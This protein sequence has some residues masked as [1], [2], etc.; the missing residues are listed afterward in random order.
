VDRSPWLGL[1]S[2]IAR[3]SAPGIRGEA[4]HGDPAVPRRLEWR[5][6][7][8]LSTDQ[9]QLIVSPADPDFPIKATTA[10][11]GTHALQAD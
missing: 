11:L 6:N 4:R 5:L 1:A 2:V 3:W 10:V 8:R 9:H 7:A